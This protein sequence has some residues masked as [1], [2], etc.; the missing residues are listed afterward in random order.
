MGWDYSKAFKQYK[1]DNFGDAE[2]LEDFIEEMHEQFYDDDMHF[3]GHSMT[4][5]I[6]GSYVFE[7]KNEK[8]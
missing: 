6:Y 7:T 5:E 2:T 8:K 3:L 4:S 1:K